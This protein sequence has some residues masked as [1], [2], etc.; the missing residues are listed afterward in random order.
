MK[1]T[2]MNS[3]ENNARL[4]KKCKLTRTKYWKFLE[5]RI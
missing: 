2:Q 1:I 4:N 3:K 5:T